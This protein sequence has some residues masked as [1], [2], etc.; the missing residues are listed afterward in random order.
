MEASTLPEPG[1]QP[2]AQTL[3]IENLALAIRVGV[4]EAERARPQRL[5]VTVRAS[6]TP[7][8]PRHD[9]VT[10]VV[11]YGRIAAG[12]RALVGSEVKLLETLA[13]TIARIAFADSRVAAVEIELRKPDLFEDC[14]VGIAARYVR[15][16][17]ATP[18][19]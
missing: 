12:I 13:G 4:G 10:E 14:C 17:V 1:P 16:G 7:R 2:A 19:K 8:A 18:G 11:D 6:V 3:L 9:E 15:P 5:L